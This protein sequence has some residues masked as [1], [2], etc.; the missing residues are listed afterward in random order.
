MYF[1]CNKKRNNIKNKIKTIKEIKFEPNDNNKEK[2][3]NKNKVY[4]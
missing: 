2:T 3:L 1:Q 4:Y